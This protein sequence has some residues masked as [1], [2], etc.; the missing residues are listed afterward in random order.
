MLRRVDE[1]AFGRGFKALRLKRRLRQDDV[2][3]E[4]GVSRGVIARIESGRA[5]T[6]TVET[7]EKVARP[8]GARVVCRLTWQGEGLD[9]L[10]DA[11]H[12]A[13]VE[14]V[15]QILRDLGWLVAT[16]VSFNVFGERGSI[17][18]LAFH[19]VA[20]TLLVIEV[21]SVVPDVQAT[22]VTL[23]RKERLALEIARKRGW[24]AIAVAKLLVIRDDRTARRRVE[25][26]AATFGNAF[27]DRVARI[28]AWLR[29]PEPR[30]PLRGLW[31]L[32][33]ESH[34]V[35]RQRVRGAQ[36]RPERGAGRRS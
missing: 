21:K 32:S 13:I 33:N 30:R 19:P 20:R 16:E 28:R 27:P 31:F 24:D 26:H 34:A 22:L 4:S 17:D 18:V 14:Q 1:I 25:Q 11:D 7:L 15:V 23:D 9:H 10:L 6:V 8:L 3:A 2:A 35:A 36:P 12:A 29:A 5:S